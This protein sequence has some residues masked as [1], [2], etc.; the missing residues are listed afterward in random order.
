MNNFS[1]NKDILNQFSMPNNV[2]QANSQFGS[3]NLF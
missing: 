2:F 1:R 3:L